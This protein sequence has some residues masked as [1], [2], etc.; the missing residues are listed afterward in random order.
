M[1]LCV[2]AGLPACAPADQGDDAVLAPVLL[3]TDLPFQYPPS[4]FEARVEGQV[5]LR[6]YVDSLGLVVPE[7]TRVAEP[8]AHPAFD[9]AAVAGAPYLEFRP[10]QRGTARLG[11]AV[12]LPVQFRLPRTDSTAGDTIR[13]GT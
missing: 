1:V 3:T 2:V 11:Q 7:S 10:A 12:V 4:L 9:S 6:L 5:A 13:G 8:S